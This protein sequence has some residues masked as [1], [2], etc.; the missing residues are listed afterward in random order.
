MD[1]EELLKNLEDELKWFRNSP[2]K[3]S[4]LTEDQVDYLIGL[5]EDEIEFMKDVV[6]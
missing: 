6:A 4:C 5:V 3:V 1:L 2:E